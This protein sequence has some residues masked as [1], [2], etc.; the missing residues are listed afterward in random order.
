VV[1]PSRHGVTSPSVFYLPPVR[2]R[3]RIVRTEP[4][5]VSDVLI[6]Y[7]ELKIAFAMSLRESDYSGPGAGT[8][9]AADKKMLVFT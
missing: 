9:D 7:D 1:L 3:S 5:I 4:H 6:S 2:H 8:Y